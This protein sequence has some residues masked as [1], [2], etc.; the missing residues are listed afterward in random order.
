M[1]AY[2][3][4]V[5]SAVGASMTLLV[6][7]GLWPMILLGLALTT[8]TA[9][10]PDWAG[11]VWLAFTLGAPVVIATAGARSVERRSRGD[12]SS[13]TGALIAS[14]RRSETKSNNF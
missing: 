6:E 1:F 10:R 3:F 12:L 9:L 14:E 13:P 2:D 4:L 8:T 5:L 11:H 7:R